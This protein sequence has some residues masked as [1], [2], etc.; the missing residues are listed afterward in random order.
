MGKSD[1]ALISKIVPTLQRFIRAHMND[2]ALPLPVLTFRHKDVV[3]LLR[4]TGAHFSR[5]QMEDA[6][7]ELCRSD[8]MSSHCT[9]THCFQ[10]IYADPSCTTHTGTTSYPTVTQL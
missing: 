8:R 3:K 5:E 4:K 2:E 7:T 9:H 1:W 6:G 10:A